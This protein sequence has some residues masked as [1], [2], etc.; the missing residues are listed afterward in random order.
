MSTESKKRGKRPFV[1]PEGVTV[2]WTKTNKQVALQ[3]GVS[4]MTAMNLRKRLGVKP[5]ERG[6]PST[7]VSLTQNNATT[8]TT[9]TTT[10]TT[11]VVQ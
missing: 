10:E 11:N 8:T 2:D 6:R 3:L 5:N 1:I 7:V 9:T 4:M